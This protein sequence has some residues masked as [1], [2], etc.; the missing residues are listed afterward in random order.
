MSKDRRRQA[1]ALV[2]QPA[3]Q[4]AVSQQI[5]EL[6]DTVE[7]MR[8]CEDCG[9]NA[10]RQERSEQPSHRLPQD[11]TTDPLLGEWTNEDDGN[12]PVHVGWAGFGA[13]R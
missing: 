10:D 4:Q 12:A 8:Q 3:E 9:S 5:W 13:A 6:A 7:S 11:A 1:T 2:A